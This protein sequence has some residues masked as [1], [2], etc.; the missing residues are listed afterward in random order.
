MNA[1]LGTGM[2]NSDFAARVSLLCELTGEE[3]AELGAEHTVR[4]E[5]S[6]FADLS[7]HFGEVAGLWMGRCALAI[8]SI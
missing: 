4:D 8:L 7:G 3:L 5:F 1:D 2:R 6:L